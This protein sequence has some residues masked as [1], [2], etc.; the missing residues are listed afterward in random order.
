[1]PRANR[2]FLPGYVWHITH[3]CHRRQFLLKF[4]RDRRRW[5]YW[6]FEST[7]RYGL[8]VLNYAVTSN[9][10][11]LLVQDRGE[12]E[13]ARSLQLIAGR[14]AQEYN[15]RKGRLGAYWQDRYHATA[16]DA[17]T[18]LARCLVYI[19]LNMVRAGV[20]RHPREWM[21][22]G[23]REIQAPPKRYRIIDQE[24]LLKLLGVNDWEA[25]QRL[26]A[27]WVEEALRSDELSRGEAWSSALAVGS[28]AFAEKIKAQ[29][30]TRACHRQVD[31]ADEVAVLREAPPPYAVDSD[32]EMAALNVELAPLAED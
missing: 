21:E 11:H 2:H 29:L 27:A 24:A 12:G 25:L 10:I 9:H 19:D 13:I 14:T 26:H 7:R 16:I 28:P 30:G 15:Q 4:A 23:Y 18:H 32:N 20:V 3:R 1:V 6:L 22:S 31:G 17:D 8:S 5:L